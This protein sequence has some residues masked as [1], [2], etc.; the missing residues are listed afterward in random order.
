ME[1]L[2]GSRHISKEVKREM[3]QKENA[4]QRERR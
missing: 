2:E 1:K 3:V 4:L